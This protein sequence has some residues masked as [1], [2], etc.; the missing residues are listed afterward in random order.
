M[1]FLWIGHGHLSK[2][3]PRGNA[4]GNLLQYV[5]PEERLSKEELIIAK[6]IRRHFFLLAPLSYLNLVRRSLFKRPHMALKSPQS[7]V[8][9]A[10]I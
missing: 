7:D 3:L 2:V 1:Q 5:P 4:K 8:A 9:V 6:T 10:Y